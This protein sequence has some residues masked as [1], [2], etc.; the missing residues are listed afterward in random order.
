[1]EDICSRIT[2]GTS[3]TTLILEGTNYRIDKMSENNRRMYEDLDTKYDEV[4]FIEE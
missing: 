3:V 1:M 4:C 2:V